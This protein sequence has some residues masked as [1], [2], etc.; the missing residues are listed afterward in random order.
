MSLVRLTFF[1]V[2][3]PQIRVHSFWSSCNWQL[4]YF[5][6][7]DVSVQLLVHPREI[8]DLSD[9]YFVEQID[10]PKLLVVAALAIELGINYHLSTPYL[11]NR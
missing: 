5:D 6:I 8:L 3:R 2:L 7:V 10:L 11:A 9:E 1:L 4:H